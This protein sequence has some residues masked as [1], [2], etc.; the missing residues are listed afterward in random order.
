MGAMLSVLNELDARHVCAVT[1]AVAGLQNA[2]V[3]AG[4]RRELRPDLLEQLVRRF[5]LL[6]VAAGQPARVQR[7]GAGLRD[8]LLDE[9]PQF[10]GLRL[11]GLDGPALDER[12]REVTHER[13][14]LLARAAQLPS[15]LPVTHW[16][17]SSSSSGAAAA[18]WLGGVPQSSTRTPSPFSSNRIPKFKPSR[19]SRSA[20][21]WSDFF[22]KFFTCRIWLSV[23]R[24]RS[25][26]LRMLEFLSEFTDR[27][28]SSR[29]SIGVFSNCC[30]RAPSVPAPS[31]PPPATGAELCEPNSTK[32]WKWVCASAAA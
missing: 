28:D 6:D 24:T 5:P 13:E 2:R 8:E 26:R 1:L 11:G 3:T 27:T 7:A 4:P 19:S 22:P 30:I 32:Y 17:Y 21:S 14:L 16:C 23:W 31:A 25:P 18:A 20:I 15:C 29:S 12:G 9:R 10:L